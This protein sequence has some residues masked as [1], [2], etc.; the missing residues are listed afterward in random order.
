MDNSCEK[1]KNS[2]LYYGKRK[3]KHSLLNI[4]NKKYVFYNFPF[5]SFFMSFVFRLKNENS[6]IIS[7]NENN[8]NS[9]ENEY[10]NPIIVSQNENP[11]VNCADQL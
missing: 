9:T 3:R 1:N 4:K 7:E 8:N 2:N 5:I 10:S 11:D 6:T